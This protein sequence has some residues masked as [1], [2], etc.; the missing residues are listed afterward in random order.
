MQSKYLYSVRIRSNLDSSTPI[1]YL[2]NEVVNKLLL[3]P[4]T[5]LNF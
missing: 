3:Q 4:V 2:V 1:E 5:P